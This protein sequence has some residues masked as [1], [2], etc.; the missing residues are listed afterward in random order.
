MAETGKT[1]VTASGVASASALA[2][3]IL[4]LVKSQKAAAAAENGGFTL[5]PEL[6][7]LLAAMAIDVETIKNLI[8]QGGGTGAGY[9]PNAKYPLSSRI[10]LGAALTA[11]NFQDMEIPDDFVFVVKAYPPPVN[12]AG[13]LVYVGRSKSEAQD[14]YTSYPL[15]PS[16]TIGYKI[17]NASAI[18]VSGS[19]ANLS[20]VWTVE[21]R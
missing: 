7:E 14:P 3:S 13:S 12:P 18:W 5:P 16:E 21:Q 2:V 20:V 10:D 9:P 6:L 8:G 11:V 1:R 4:A 19:I 15:M 17:E